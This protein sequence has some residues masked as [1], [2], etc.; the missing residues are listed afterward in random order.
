MRIDGIEATALTRNSLLRGRNPPWILRLLTPVPATADKHIESTRGDIGR[1][2]YA[3]SDLRAYLSFEASADDAPELNEVLTT[4]K[5]G[6][7]ADVALSW[8][9]HVLNPT[10]HRAKTADYSF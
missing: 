6:R 2:V 8:L 9:T 10:R 4:V 5:M 7:R 3:L 1:G